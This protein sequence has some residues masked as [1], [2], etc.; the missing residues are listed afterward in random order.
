MFHCSVC[1]LL[2]WESLSC[3]SIYIYH[4]S[5]TSS[6]AARPNTELQYCCYPHPFPYNAPNASISL[7]LYFITPCPLPLLYWN[8]TKLDRYRY[9]QQSWRQCKR[10]MLQATLQHFCHIATFFLLIQLRNKNPFYQIPILFYI[11]CVCVCISL[12]K[13]NFYISMYLKKKSI[14]LFQYII[15]KMYNVVKIMFDIKCLLRKL[16]SVTE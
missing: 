2:T 1:Q 8:K 14:R 3:H 16:F 6:P 11:Y 9:N 7:P 13:L 5:A 15:I 12:N 10:S 4:A